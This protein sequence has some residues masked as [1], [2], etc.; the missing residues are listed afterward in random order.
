ML[1]NKGAAVNA[2]NM[3]DD[4]ALHLAAA[5]GHR[6]IVNLL[7][8]HKA[9]LNAV[10]E[11]GNT[12]LHYACFCGYQNIA[13]DLINAGA[14][15]NITNKYGDLPLDKCKGHMVQKLHELAE[16]MGQD[17]T[18]KVPYKVRLKMGV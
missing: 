2:T 14:L 8:K 10:N 15:V 11:H 6:E 7:L 5:H 18:T 16:K 4:T 1:I 9:D 13:E 17:V 3:G 12:P